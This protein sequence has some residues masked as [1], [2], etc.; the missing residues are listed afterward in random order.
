MKLQRFILVALAALLMSA[1]PDVLAQSDIFI[2]PK[3]NQ[4]KEQQDRDRYECH[5]WAVNQTGFD[6]STAAA[7]AAAPPQTTGTADSSTGPD[8]SVIAGAARGAA[9]GAI[10]GEIFDDKAG[11]GAAAGAAVGALR[12]GRARRERRRQQAQ[13]AE[14][15]QPQV[16]Q[17]AAYQKNYGNY[18]KAQKA[19]LEARDYSVQ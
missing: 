5:R 1:A 2:Y 4:T 19:C 9:V 7:P 18:K 13:Q 14:V 16:E 15:S 10:A 6:P 12:G 17:N 11:K 3:N 8:G